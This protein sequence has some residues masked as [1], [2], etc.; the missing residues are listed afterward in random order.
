MAKTK[1]AFLCPVAESVH[2]IIFQHTL[3]MLSYASQNDVEINQVGVTHRT[4]IHTARNNLSKGFL[5]TDCEWAFWMDCDMLLPRNTI[6]RL[7]E[8]AKEKESKFVTGIYYQRQGEHFPVLWKKDPTDLEGN[9]LHS[10]ENLVK[11]KRGAWQHHFLVPSKDADRPF[12]ADVCGFGCVLTH[13]E[14]FEKIPYPYFKTISDEC[15]E[16][17]YFS[18]KAKREGFQL[19]ADPTM[20]LGHMADPPFITKYDC[21][22]DSSKLK[23]VKV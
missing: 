17:F 12:K 7:L 2:P 21:R 15:S 4:L 13:R 3:A 23:P 11:D 6:N 14:M 10:N 16:D 1:V 19:W 9:T 22:I 18:V 8:V 5:A 20:N